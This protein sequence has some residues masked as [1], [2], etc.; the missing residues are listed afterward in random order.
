VLATNKVLNLDCI[1][2]FWS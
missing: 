1:W 2:I